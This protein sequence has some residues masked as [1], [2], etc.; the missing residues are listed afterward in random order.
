MV[1]VSS[2][3]QIVRNI[4]A[5][6]LVGVAPVCGSGQAVELADE[7]LVDLSSRV[8]VALHV[9]LAARPLPVRAPFDATSRETINVCALRAR[10]GGTF[11]PQVVVELVAIGLEVGILIAQRCGLGQ[12]CWSQRGEEDGDEVHICCT[13]NITVYKWVLS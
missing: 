7:L 8:D 1:D 4:A 6:V 10:G 11:P 2:S 13:T 9:V 3:E 5:N 12:C